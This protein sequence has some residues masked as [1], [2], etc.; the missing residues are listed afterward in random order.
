MYF[1][2]LKYVLLYNNILVFY[3]ILCIKYIY[4]FKI[5]YLCYYGIDKLCSNYIIY[6]IEIRRLSVSFK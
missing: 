2:I 6:C 1:K 5:F 4:D 3:N